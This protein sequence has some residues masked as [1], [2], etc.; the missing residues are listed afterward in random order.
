MEDIKILENL[1]E[2]VALFSG[3]WRPILKQEEIQAIEN[4]IN[5]NKELEEENRIQRGQLNSA[6]DRGFIHKDKIREKIE[7]RREKLIK[8]KRSY[9]NKIRIN[10]LNLISK[11]LLED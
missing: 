10:E 3:G 6:F 5:R 9:T 4:L 1:K 11:I 8:G 2:N 7:E